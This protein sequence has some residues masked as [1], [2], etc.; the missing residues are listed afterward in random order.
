MSGYGGTRDKKELFDKGLMDDLREF[1]GAAIHYEADSSTGDCT[2]PDDYKHCR[3]FECDT[4]GIIKF[5]YLTP[6]GNTA[7]RVMIAQA[8]INH[9]RNITRVYRYYKDT[10]ACTAS[11]YNSAGASKVGI[12]LVS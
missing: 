2:V 9:Y 1:L 6:A 4:A 10:T 12:V 8:G 11:I 3:Y 5:D 7:T